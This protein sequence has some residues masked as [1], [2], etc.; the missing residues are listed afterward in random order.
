MIRILPNNYEIFPIQKD[1]YMV[2]QFGLKYI[3]Y[4][5]F[6]SDISI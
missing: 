3:Y 1:I 4:F 6:I 2:C 5:V